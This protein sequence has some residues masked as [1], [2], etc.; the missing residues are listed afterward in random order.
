M[1]TVGLSLLSL[2]TPHRVEGR[3]TDDRDESSPQ[4]RP[5]SVPQFPHLKDISMNPMFSPRLSFY[6]H[7]ISSAFELSQQIVAALLSVFEMPSFFAECNF[8]VSPFHYTFFL[9]I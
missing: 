5:L 4:A 9:M 3:D 1:E 6:T 8:R 7:F 2:P